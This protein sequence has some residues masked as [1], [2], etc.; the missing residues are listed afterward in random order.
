M[1]KLVR[2]YTIPTDIAD[3]LGGYCKAQGLK[4]S[5]LVSALLAGVRDGE[6]VIEKQPAALVA[7]VRE[8]SLKSVGSRHG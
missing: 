7:K 1:N 3:W 8:P 2:T 5:D 6:I 4:R